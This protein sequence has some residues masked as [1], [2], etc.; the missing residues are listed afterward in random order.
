MNNLLPDI[1]LAHILIVWQVDY[2]FVEDEGNPSA[3]SWSSSVI[4]IYKMK[5]MIQFMLMPL[6]LMLAVLPSCQKDGTSPVKEPKM[7]SLPPKG[8]VV[9]RDGNHFGIEL[10]K[11]VGMEE[12]GNMMLSPV[13]A[14]VAITMLL[15]GC[16]SATYEQVRDMLGYEGLTLDEINDTYKSLVTQLLE[17]DPEVTLALANAVWYKDQ[18]S[19]NPEFLAA[20]S[21]SFEA[22]IQA[23][24]FQD[25]NTLDVINGWASESTFGKI[26][27]VLNEIDDRQ[28]MFLMN[29]LYFKGNWTYRFDESHTAPAPFFTDD[30]S[31]VEVETM[32]R[33]IPA[34]LHTAE[35]YK[36]IELPYGRQNFAMDIIVPVSNMGTFLGNF[37]GDDW[38]SLTSALDG[39][40]ETTNIQVSLPKFRFEYE[41]ILNEELKS[42]G[43]T[44]AFDPGLADL[45][46]ISEEDIFVNFVKQNTFVEV[47]EEGT[48]AAA[49]TTI[50]IV[51]TSMP[52]SF[53]V[54]KPFI[55]VIRERTT[56]SILFIGKV[57][58]PA[59]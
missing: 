13:S 32:S 39:Q 34:R 45:S 43:M 54:D 58:L 56:N 27:K 25:P 59:I 15:N 5:A 28:V 17:A 14:S 22:R 6:A 48:E 26:N 3:P 33:E 11:A 53:I 36:A 31:T 41:K 50:G 20:M 8:E 35:S 46:G 21:A 47:N 12:E 38:V 24:D 55:F 2:F 57:S 23:L 4:I 1:N 49:V 51:G 52:E 10:F 37:T 7:L 30:G 29:A 19:V 9:I 18:F 44:D 16:Q 42:L 40:V